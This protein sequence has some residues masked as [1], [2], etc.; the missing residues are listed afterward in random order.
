M[1]SVDDVTAWMRNVLAVDGRWTVSLPH[2]RQLAVYSRCV[3]PQL[4]RLGCRL[5]TV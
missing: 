1:M 4:Q 5:L 2:R 3:E